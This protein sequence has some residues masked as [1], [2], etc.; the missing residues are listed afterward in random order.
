MMEFKGQRLPICRRCADKIM[1][2]DLEWG[3][4]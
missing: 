2:S 4:E 3:K 1:V